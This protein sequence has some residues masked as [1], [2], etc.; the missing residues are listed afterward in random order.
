M[1]G[2]D[3]RAPGGGPN[4]QCLPS[5]PEYST[6]SNLTAQFSDLMN[7]R[8]WPYPK[9]LDLHLI[10][11]AVCETNQRV[12]KLMIP[13]K[14]RCPSDDW[15]LEYQGILNS[16]ASQLPNGQLIPDTDIQH[17]LLYECIDSEMESFNG[18]TLTNNFT[19]YYT[20]VKARCT[21]EGALV[22]SCPPYQSDK[23]LSCVVCSK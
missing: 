4:V 15:V 23:P 20:P 7:V 10:P 6:S 12:T 9:P 17:K 2:P 5:Y 3:R 18:R 14:T 11:C 13:A 1:A 19:P 8:Y 16:A 22:N 21:G